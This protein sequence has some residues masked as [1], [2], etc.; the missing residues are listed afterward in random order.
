MNRRTIPIMGCRTQLNSRPSRLS[1]PSQYIGH[2]MSRSQREVPKLKGAGLAMAG[3]L[4][5][6]VPKAT[7]LAYRVHIVATPTPKVLPLTKILPK[8]PLD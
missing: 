3:L 4:Q 8:S 1:R 6:G 5:L 2:G 7:M